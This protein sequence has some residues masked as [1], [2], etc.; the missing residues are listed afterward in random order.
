M[1]YI[2]LLDLSMDFDDFEFDIDEDPDTFAEFCDEIHKEEKLHEKNIN[3]CSDFG[4]QC[5]DVCK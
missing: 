5:P 2:R 4:E 1:D 3:P